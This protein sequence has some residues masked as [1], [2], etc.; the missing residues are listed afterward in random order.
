M[1][2][3]Y[4]DTLKNVAKENIRNPRELEKWLEE[5]NRS[6]VEGYFTRS[7]SKEAKDYFNIGPNYERLVQKQFNSLVNQIVSERNMAI[8]KLAKDYENAT[9]TVERN[10][11][12]SQIRQYEQSE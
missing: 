8:K 10:E 2:D 4:W 1:Y 9:S 3:F 6:Y 12:K 11:L 5:N 7:L